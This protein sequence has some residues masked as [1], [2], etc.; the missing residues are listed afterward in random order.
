MIEFRGNYITAS[1]IDCIY[2]DKNKSNDFPFRL[3][4]I[5]RNGSR[6]GVSYKQERD[7]DAEKARIA[8]SV[9]FELRQDYE[10]MLNRLYL[11]NDAVKRIDRR[12]L[13]IWR[14][15]KRLLDVEEEEA[16]AAL[17]ARTEDKG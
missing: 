7:R 3:T 16:E 4:V 11:I 17:E 9:E 14:Q 6:V 2:C 1:Q 15:L 13:Q 12:Q 10:K 8:R 5:M